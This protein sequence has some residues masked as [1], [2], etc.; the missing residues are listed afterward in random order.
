ME[1]IKQRLEDNFK[2]ENLPEDDIIAQEYKQVT[3]LLE[4][5]RKSRNGN[6]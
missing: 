5:M 6:N 1:E 3:D 2:I 4:Q